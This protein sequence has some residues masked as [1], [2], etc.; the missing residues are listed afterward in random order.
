MAYST[1]KPKVQPKSEKTSPL[2]NQTIALYDI[3]GR[4]AMCAD[5]A[6]HLRVFL[7]LKY[8][9][10]DSKYHNVFLKNRAEI[11]RD[12]GISRDRLYRILKYLRE[13]KWLYTTKDGFH[14]TIG[15][16]AMKNFVLDRQ[17]DILNA[18]LE[19]S[20]IGF[21]KLIRFNKDVLLE[22]TQNFK[23]ELQGRIIVN[24]LIKQLYR[25]DFKKRQKGGRN[26][27]NCF[28]SIIEGSTG[29][30]IDKT[31]KSLDRTNVYNE[32]IKMSGAKAGGIFGKTE[33]YGYTLLNQL[34]EAGFY[35]FKKHEM[36]IKYSTIAKRN[37]NTKLP[38]FDKYPEWYLGN[39]Y[40]VYLPKGIFINMGREIKLNIDVL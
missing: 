19:A 12:L 33:R 25:I 37:P 21:N 16:K 30:G 8:Y 17:R 29:M 26:I 39:G 23:L 1:N 20:Q 9:R 3:V 10:S 15:S 14:R 36:F 7:Y 40:E 6:P 11:C 32:Q 22:K 27:N 5:K 24:A 4:W 28:S 2:T 34:E 35:V 13:I 38:V 18:S 31:V